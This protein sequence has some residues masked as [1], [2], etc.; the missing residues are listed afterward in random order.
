MNEF[1]FNV[2]DKN[3]VENICGCLSSVLQG[4]VPVIV[5]IGTDLSIGDSLGPLTGT[6]LTEKDVNTFVYGKFNSLITAKRVIEMKGFIDSAHKY[7]KTLVI[8]AAIG[9]KEDIGNIKISVAPLKPGLGARKN[10]P[11]IG[12]ISIIG[13]VAEK[14]GANYSFLNLTRLSPIYKMSKILS[15]AIEKYVKT[16]GA[17]RNAV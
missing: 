5:C 14:S 6:M 2:N 15:T 10:L 1:V 9:K 12:D 8:D 13:V 11:S 17:E 7:T 4:E 3:V 16:S